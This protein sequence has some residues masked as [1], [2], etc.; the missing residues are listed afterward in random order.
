MIEKG[1][2]TIKIRK[3]EE[4]NII[5]EETIEFFKLWK[6]IKEHFMVI[7]R[8]KYK[9]SKW[10]EKSSRNQSTIK[11]L[12]SQEKVFFLNDKLK[13]RSKLSQCVFLCCWMLKD[14]VENGIS[15]ILHKKIALVMRR[16]EI[17]LMLGDDRCQW[18]SQYR[19]FV[20]ICI[21]PYLCSFFSLLR[22][23]KAKI[24]PKKVYQKT[25]TMN[26]CGLY[27]IWSSY[28]SIVINQFEKSLQTVRH[29]SPF[30]QYII[31][32]KSIQK[33]CRNSL[34]C[35]RSSGIAS[36]WKKIRK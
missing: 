20:L 21:C 15:L 33:T 17:C 3:F 32:Q 31:C 16:L 11:L 10:W 18:Q 30:L 7:K 8:E 12:F 35:K 2:F 22:K 14:Q 28:P 5:S 25:M 4:K 27:F 26:E 29:L 36:K 6:G 9:W 1:K 19:M 34:E 24:S 23:R 13:R